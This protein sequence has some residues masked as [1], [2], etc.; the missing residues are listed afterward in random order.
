M[1]HKRIRDSKGRLAS[2]FACAA[3][4]IT[5]KIPD[6]DCGVIVALLDSLP[7][8]SKR[9]EEFMAHAFEVALEICLG[10]VAF[11]L[12]CTAVFFALVSRK[13]RALEA[14]RALG[15]QGAHLAT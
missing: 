14:E 2:G 3:G 12:L 4:Y 1:C 5:K 8:G 9:P 7:T 6:L 13:D 15:E 11:S 10:Y